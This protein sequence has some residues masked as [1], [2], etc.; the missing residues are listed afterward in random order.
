L[1]GHKKKLLAGRYLP[2]PGIVWW[3]LPEEPPFSQLLKNFQTFSVTRNVITML[4]RDLHQP[5][6]VHTTPSYLKSILMLSSPP[7]PNLLTSWSWGIL[8]KSSIVQLLK[9]FQTFYGTPMFIN[10]STKALHW[11]QIDG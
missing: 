1:A 4:R 9:D 6:P 2:T 10:M 5:Q 7:M 11:P 8:E 3:A